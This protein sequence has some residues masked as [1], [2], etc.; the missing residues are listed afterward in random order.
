MI[1]F[2]E[3]SHN[4]TLLSGIKSNKTQFYDPYSVCCVGRAR[5]AFPINKY[6][7]SKSLLFPLMPAHSFMLMMT[8]V[9]KTINL[10]TTQAKIVCTIMLYDVCDTLL[11]C[12]LIV[13]SSEC[14]N[15]FNFSLI[16][17]IKTLL[18]RVRKK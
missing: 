5:Y 12:L 15:N 13:V 16:F 9:Q 1:C 4:P 10:T 11:Y 3:P 6:F 8:V 2:V 17:P 18:R 7:S 14:C